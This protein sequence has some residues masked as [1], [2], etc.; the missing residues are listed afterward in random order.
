MLD[1]PMPPSLVPLYGD[2]EGND[3]DDINQAHCG[4]GGD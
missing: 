3:N 4:A 2:P 1:G